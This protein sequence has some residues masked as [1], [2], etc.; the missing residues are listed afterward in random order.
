MSRA[1]T[2]AIPADPAPA[3]ANRRLGVTALLSVAALVAGILSAPAAAAQPA[4]NPA[5]PAPESAPPAPESAPAIPPTPESAAPTTPLTT[6]APIADGRQVTFAG[7]TVTVPASWPVITLDGRPGCVRYDEHA[8][9]LGDPSDVTCPA[10]LIG[11]TSTVQ[12]LRDDPAGQGTIYDASAVPLVVL[13]DSGDDLLVTVRGVVRAIVTV[14]PADPAEAYGVAASVTADGQR[15]ETDSTAA[16]AVTKLV[17][18]AAAAELDDPPGDP[19]GDSTTAPPAPEG[20]RTAGAAFHA[21]AAAANP[22]AVSSYVMA[23]DVTAPDSPVDPTL[24]AP[25]AGSGNFRGMA[26][27]TCAAPSVAAMDA[28]RES[29]YGAVGIYIGG[30]SA[31]CKPGTDRNPNLTADWVDQVARMGWKMIPIYVGMQAPGT[32]YS[33]QISTKPVKATQ[34]GVESAQDAVTKMAALGLGPGNPIYLD[35]EAWNTKDTA[36]NAAVI[37]FTHGWTQELHRL[38]YQSGFYSS[39]GGG[40]NVIANRTVSNPDFLAPDVMW[41]ARWYSQG[42][43]TKP[44]ARAQLIAAAHVDA[45]AKFDAAGLL[46]DTVIPDTLWT[47]QQRGWQYLG[48]HVVKHGDFAINIDSNLW[49]GPVAP[50]TTEAIT[51]AN[52]SLPDIAFNAKYSTTITAKGQQAGYR[53]AATDGL[54]PPGITLAQNGTLSGKTSRLGVWSFTVLVTDSKRPWRFGARTYQ[55]VSTFPDLGPSNTF[56]GDI[57]WLA[58]SRITTG[59]PD[60]TFRPGGSVTRQEMA[61]YLYRYMHPDA[62]TAPTCIYNAFKDVKKTDRFCGEIRWLAGT[63]ITTGYADG[64]FRPTVKISRQEI[65]AFLYR[66]QHPEE[67]PGLLAQQQA[68][69]ELAKEKAAHV[70]DLTTA[71][72]EA[73]AAVTAA[74]KAVKAAKADLAAAVKP[75]AK[76]KAEK[77]LATAEG[78]LNGATE[79]LRQARAD[80]AAAVADAK[81]PPPNRDTCDVAPMTDITADALF[82]RQISWLV[83]TNITTG[84]SSGNYLPQQSVLRGQMAAFLHRLAAFSGLADPAADPGAGT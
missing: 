47:N 16:L 37:S 46:R 26:F 13:S 77:A 61:A 22:A 82:C 27:D 2:R 74:K 53:F 64:T 29:T 34:Q 32:R 7:L 23:P 40:I 75:T 73:T 55:L 84:D 65:A 79:T 36:A 59:Y 72:A 9:F 52:P 66:L 71:V 12:L 25:T 67:T 20:L 49:D 51:I 58:N 54:L 15:A 60:G 43:L 50:A 63:G 6:P 38:K 21:P 17:E 10:R 31:S 56:T 11:R 19:A 42:D 35:V 8:A 30:V 78:V 62:P 39:S 18:D 4:P 41:F 69:R 5:A 70:A 68:D 80:L 83:S 3:A 57:A 1:T 76:K 48:G 14:D 28:W 44:K 33:A 24:Q 81:I 45:Q